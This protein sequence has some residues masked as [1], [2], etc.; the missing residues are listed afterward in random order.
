LPARREARLRFALG[1]YF[2][3]VKDFEQAFTH[4]R[5]ANELIR[6][7]SP[8]YA[9]REVTLYTD[10][11]TQVYDQE[12]LASAR[13]HVP[14]SERAVFIVGMW[15]SG[16]TLAEQ[17][18][19]SH[20]DV[21]GAGELPYWR[22]AAVQYETS[23]PEQEGGDDAGLAVLCA[24]YLAQ[25]GALSAGARRVID[26]MSANFLHLG[27]IHAAL[28]DARIIHMQRDPI[29]TCLSIYFQSFLQS[30][31]YATDL[32]DLAHY[33]TQYQRV[34]EH[35]RRTLPEGALL[36]VPYEGLVADPEAWSRRM[37]EFVGLPWNPRC[38]DFHLTDRVVTT[39]SKWQVRQPI[40]RASVERWRNYERFIGPLLKLR[41]VQPMG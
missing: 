25:I 13:R 40:H 12:W 22:S 8:P 5:R 37:L 26:K 2:D 9:R 7:Q 4:Y 6:Q 36:E 20:P 15:R 32:D 24:D 30:Q 41:P 16:T 35:W 31:S 34:M 39:L 23:S 14:G 27:V 33:Y 21:F 28:P 10:L 19:A 18:L 3:D 1:K 11:V 29:D 38:L 17:I